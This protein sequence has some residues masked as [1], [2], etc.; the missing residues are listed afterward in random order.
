M[1][2]SWNPVFLR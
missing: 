1:K 2:Q